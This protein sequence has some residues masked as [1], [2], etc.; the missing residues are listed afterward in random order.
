MFFAPPDLHTRIMPHAARPQADEIPVRSHRL[1]DRLLP[2]GGFGREHRLLGR[3]LPRRARDRLADKLDVACFPVRHRWCR[4]AFEAGTTDHHLRQR[5]QRPR[6]VALHH[7]L[8]QDGEP[9]D[10]QKVSRHFALRQHRHRHRVCQRHRRT[11]RCSPV[12]SR[13]SSTPATWSSPS[14]AAATR[15]CREGRRVCESGGSRNAGDCRLRRRNAEANRQALVWVP[16]FDM[17]L[18]EDVHLM[19][20]HMVMKT[21]CGLGSKTRPGAP[22][23]PDPARH[24]SATDTSAAKRFP[25]PRCS[26]TGSD[27]SPAPNCA[28]SHASYESATDSGCPTDTPCSRPAQSMMRVAGRVAHHVQ[29]IH[30]ACCRGFVIGS[31]E[32]AITRVA[33]HSGA[34]ARGDARCTLSMRR[35]LRR[36]ISA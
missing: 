4:R 17:Q 23:R 36:R 7:R 14:A 12:S 35:S 34:R 1:P 18:C 16:S 8:E 31:D 21:L 30:V 19:F 11:T 29:V 26:V 10:R 9:G 3:E 5:R 24:S 20:G 15:Q 27:P 22:R 13:R 33:R 32:A 6:G 28:I 25:A 2:A